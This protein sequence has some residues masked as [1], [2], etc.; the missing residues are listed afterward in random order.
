MALRR[1]LNISIL[2]RIVRRF[3]KGQRVAK[4][5]AILVGYVNRTFAFADQ[6]VGDAHTNLG[7]IPQCYDPHL[8]LFLSDGFCAKVYRAEKI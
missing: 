5:T 6:S 8:F 4:E 3:V 7:V 2:L 1:K